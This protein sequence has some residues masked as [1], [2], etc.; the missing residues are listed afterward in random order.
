VNELNLTLQQFIDLIPRYVLEIAETLQASGFQAY[1]VGGSIRDVLLGKKPEDYDIATNA[2]PEQIEKIFLKSIPTG[3]KFGTMTVV[4]SDEKGE[5]FD[6]EVTTFRSEADYVGG[7]WPSK[8]EYAKTIE[9]DLSRRDFTMNAIALDLQRFDEPNISIQ[10]ILIDP[11]NGIDDIKNKLIRAVREPLERFSE[12]GLRAVRACRLAAQLE[13]EI[14]ENTFNAMKETN[15]ITKQVSIER[16][17]DELMKLLKKSPKPSIG[18]KLM[19]DSGILKIFIPE[20]LEGEGVTQPEFHVDDVFEH[21]LK[22]VDVA[23]DSVKLAALFHDIGKP[24]TQITGDDGQVHFYGHDKVGAEMTEEI[25]RRLKFSNEEIK[26]VSTLVRWHM[27]YYPSANWR[28]ELKQ[29]ANSLQ[30]AANNNEGSEIKSFEP[31]EYAYLTDDDLDFSL[32]AEKGTKQQGGWTNGAVRRLMMNVGGDGAIDD[33]LKLRIADAG[34]NPKSPF[35]PKEIDALSD[36]IAEVRAEEAAM[37]ITDLD[38]TGYDLMKELSLEAGPILGEILNYLLDIVIEEPI[39][40]KKDE[41]LS[42]ARDYLE[43]RD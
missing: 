1:L 22:A 38:I 17:R 37:K 9:E 26:K 43:T 6:V 11:F 18:L 20:L 40:N 27:F 34:A 42:L 24:R 10:Q 7:R 31:D 13:F 25:M 4:I 23:E 5:S 39:K 21:S 12:D 35:N 41:L 2:Y 30:P 32:K 3:A 33:L 16:F 8:V 28:K 29:A 14:E 19:K 15:H 36:R